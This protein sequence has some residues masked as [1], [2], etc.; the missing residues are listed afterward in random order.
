MGELQKDDPSVHDRYAT[1]ETIR[2]QTTTASFPA[3]E[4][5]PYN[6]LST[7]PNL[8]SDQTKI[9]QRD[10]RVNQIERP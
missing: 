10:T 9:T 3:M 2:S 7:T 6:P 4:S 1:E 8:G 5:R